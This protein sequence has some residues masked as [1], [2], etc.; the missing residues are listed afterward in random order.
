MES[1]K[2]M[3]RN[4]LTQ[5][6]PF[7]H[8]LKEK[9]LWRGWIKNGQALEISWGDWIRGFGIGLTYQSSGNPEYFSRTLFL[10]F[11]KYYIF[12]PLGFANN[13]MQVDI[14][15]GPRY[16][17]EINKL[18]ISFH[19]NKLYRSIRWPWRHHTIS[20]ECQFK[21][22]SWVDKICSLSNEL[23][24]ETYPYKYVLKSG[25]VQEVNATVSKTRYIMTYIFFKYIKWRPTWIEE[26]I[27]VRFDKCIGEQVDTWK[28][29]V[30]G[31]G[32]DL[33]PN[34]TMEQCLRR[35]EANE[36]FN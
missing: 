17:I 29:G 8:T 4:I 30:S 6:L 26:S 22:K 34:E 31:Q 16:S 23:Y 21:D 36:K 9:Y 20:Y 12:I 13:D 18:K 28:G 33:L 7:T 11:F 32:Y 19:W 27:D 35:M 5:I 2:N 10:K 14:F 15:N 3:S 1:I 25:K 24:T